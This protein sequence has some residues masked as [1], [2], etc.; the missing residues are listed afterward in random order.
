MKVR[1]FKTKECSKCPSLIKYLVSKDI[2]YEI[3]DRDEHPIVFQRMIND[4]GL[5]TV[6]ITQIGDD[7]ITG[8]NYGRL[9]E[10]LRKNGLM[11]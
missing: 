3:I 7:Y 1:V 11:E 4:T 8:L 2:S 9:G 10:V 5:M 6:P